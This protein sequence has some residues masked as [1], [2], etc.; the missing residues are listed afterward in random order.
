M[1]KKCLPAGMCFPYDFGFIPDTKGKDGDPLDSLVISEFKTF[2]GCSIECRVIG[3]MLAE[4]KSDGKKIRNDR[5]F[6]VP[7]ASKEFE[8]H[9]SIDDLPADWLREL[10]DF[11]MLYNRF[12]KKEFKMLELARPAEAYKIIKKNLK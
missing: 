4:E 12:E 1:L 2:T 6:L 10:L 9:K 11:F 5:F 3:G 7:E 8:L